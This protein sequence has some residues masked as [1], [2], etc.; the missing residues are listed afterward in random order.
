MYCSSKNLHTGG[1]SIAAATVLK[2]SPDP[3][4]FYYIVMQYTI[5]IECLC[6]CGIS[7]TCSGKIK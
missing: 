7:L 4:F 1:S 3:S 5:F 2:E 6:I